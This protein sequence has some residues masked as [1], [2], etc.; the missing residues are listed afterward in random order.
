MADLIATLAT[1]HIVSLAFLAMEKTPPASFADD[2]E[3]AALALQF[4]PVALDRSLERGDWSFA[5][6][7]AELPPLTL[8]VTATADPALP[9][10]YSLPGDTL[11]LRE[12]GDGTVRWREDKISDTRALRADQ[13]AP[14][15]IRYTARLL[16]ETLLPAAFKDLVGHQLAIYLSPKFLGTIGK[17]E[18]IKRDHAEA[19]KMALREDARTASEARYDGLDPGLSDDW[20]AA[21]T[22]RGG[23]R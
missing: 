10:T 19:V 20:V 6:T 21:A 14:L 2:S 17:I 4:Y 11:R 16:N 9:W 18:A 13:A 23:L 12:V 22:R 1:S 15:S 8:P 5:S 3:E 7:Y